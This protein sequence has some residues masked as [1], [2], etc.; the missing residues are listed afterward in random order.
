[1]SRV[2]G[3]QSWERSKQYCPVLCHSIKVMGR[4]GK[5]MNEIFI[6]TNNHITHHM[7]ATNVFITGSS[8]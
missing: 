7:Y 6:L 5:Y 4:K 2:I 8:F 1:M 3:K